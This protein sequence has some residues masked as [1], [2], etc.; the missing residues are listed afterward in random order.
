MK[1]AKNKRSFLCIINILHHP[2][3]TLTEQVPECAEWQRNPGTIMMASRHWSLAYR[4]CDKEGPRDYDAKHVCCK[5]PTSY[6]GTA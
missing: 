2:Q 1:P 5:N 6:L 3:D 4:A